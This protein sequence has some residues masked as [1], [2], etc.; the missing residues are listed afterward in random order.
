[1]KNDKTSNNATTPP[2]DVTALTTTIGNIVLKHQCTTKYIISG[3]LKTNDA[4]YS[5]P[6]TTTIEF[7][8][9]RQSLQSHIQREMSSL[10]IG[11]QTLYRKN[12]N[13]P[14]T[15][16]VVVGSVSHATIHETP[17]EMLQRFKRENNETPYNDE[18]W[19]QHA[20]TFNVPVEMLKTIV[21]AQ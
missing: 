14:T 10:C 7:T 4:V 18:T 8:F 3:S 15:E 17:S 11:R 13:I 16:R 2:M 21:S 12:K 6:K 9:E 19:E 20:D 5:E 1:M